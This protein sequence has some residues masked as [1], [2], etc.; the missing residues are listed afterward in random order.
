MDNPPVI[1]YGVIKEIVAAFKQIAA[2][3]YGLILTAGA[4][5]D[6]GPEFAHSEFKYTTH[7]EI[8][9]GGIDTKI[10]PAFAMVNAWSTL[11]GD[12]NCYAA[13]PEGIPDGTPF[14]V[15]L[16]K[17]SQSFLSAL[18]FDYIWF[19]N[20]FGFTHF[21]WTCLGENFDG[22]RFNTADYQEQSAKIL[23]FW[24][25]FKENCPDF[26]VE[27]RGTNFGTGMDLAKDCVPLK[28]LYEGGFM[29]APACN[30]PWGPLNNDYGLELVGHMSRI[31][32][33]PGDVYPFRFYPNDPWFWQN[34]WWDWY[35]RE[36]F[37]IYTVM[38]V[39]RLSADGKIEN[40]EIIEFLTIDTELGE[41]NE[42][43]PLEVIPHIRRALQ[44]KPNQLGILT[45]LYP[46]DEYFTI[47]ETSPERMDLV[48]FGDWFVRGAVNNGL[49]LNT[50]VSTRSF[51]KVWG[52]QPGLFR[53]TILFVPTVI[54]E[55][56]WQA[57]EEFVLGGGRVMFYG[58]L[59][60]APAG[61]RDMLNIELAEGIDGNMVMKLPPERDQYLCHR[62][63][64]GFYHH[65]LVSGGAIREVVADPADGYTEIVVTVEQGSAERVYALTRQCPAWQGG[66]IAWVRGS[67]PFTLRRK[68][69]EETRL[70]EQ[71]G[72]WYFDATN[73]PRYLLGHF[74]YEISHV[75]PSQ[76]SKRPLLLVSRQDNG[77]YISG[78]KPDMT[79]GI[80]LS[81]PDGAPIFIGKDAWVEG[82]SAFYAL[83]R[84]IHDECRIFVRQS[85][86]G[87]VYSQEQPPFPTGRQRMIRLTN[88][89][90][91]AVAIYPPLDKLDTT[92][93]ILH[94]EKRKNT[95]QLDREK[96][97]ILLENITGVIDVGW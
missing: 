80:R 36:P 34:P 17:Q 11:R 28:E 55:S 58:P 49:P 88:L 24:R 75:L 43:C 72:P 63:N 48:F 37:D 57:V 27:V 50:V 83:G 82:S 10:G 85:E 54:D 68:A 21:P 23:S 90:E 30:S 51:K 19:S 38:S 5:F 41:L 33:L 13:Y 42:L 35:G 56:C 4:T 96:G 62:D 79:V 94:P 87:T 8:I 61:M 86:A 44:D 16:G 69:D 64:Q 45:W 93:I 26:P 91:A 15:F 52:G 66:K 14:G 84:T 76:T 3:E 9:G 18:G 92:E 70:P 20:G 31:A 2:E 47:A 1:T 12:Q 6:P 73:L 53:D 95:G 46:F 22:T 71:Y 77:F 89:K 97:M 40:P 29:R 81:F 25:Q 65:P 78:Y 60:T 74:G 67:N 32:E 39:A 7:P 59:D